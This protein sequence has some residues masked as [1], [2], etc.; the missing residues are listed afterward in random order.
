MPLTIQDLDG[1][2]GVGIVGEGVL[3]DGEFTEVLEGHLT[4]PEE[5]FKRHRYTIADWSGVTE[6]EVASESVVRIAVLSRQAARKNPHIVVASVAGTDLSFGLTRMWE[7]QLG[8]IPWKTK[9]FRV[10]DDAL[11]WIREKVKDLYGIEDL[12]MR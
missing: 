8:G 12:T 2:L 3:T 7:A 5:I 10:R 6:I 1:G 9:T 4:Q 11:E